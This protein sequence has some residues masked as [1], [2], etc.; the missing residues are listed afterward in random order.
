MARGEP[1]SAKRP[2][3]EALPQFDPGWAQ[4]RVPDAGIATAQTK[5][6]R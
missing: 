1:R 3:S 6:G 2:R 4:A 5:T